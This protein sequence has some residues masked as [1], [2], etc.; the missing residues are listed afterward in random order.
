LT[1]SEATTFAGRAFT[2]VEPRPNRGMR[3]WDVAVENWL[4][5][6]RINPSGLFVPPTYKDWFIDCVAPPENITPNT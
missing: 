6:G 3:P 4:L 2:V 1:T 5:P